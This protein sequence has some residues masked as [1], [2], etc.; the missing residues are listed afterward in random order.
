MAILGRN[1]DGR[2]RIA[3]LMMIMAGACMAVAVAYGSILYRAALDQQAER[4]MEIARSQASL[5]EAIAEHEFEMQG[6]GPG[7]SD[8]RLTLSQLEHARKRFKG[9]GRT[10]EFTLGKKEGDRIVFLLAH[11]HG[12]SATPR[13]VPWVSD[14]AEPM[15]LAL[16][17]FSGTMKGKDYRGAT[18]LAAHEPI[19]HL[20]LGIVAKMDLSE[21]RRPFFHAAL[22]AAGVT[23]FVVLLGVFLF[24]RISDPM[25]RRLEDHAA[26]LEREVEERRQAQEEL[27]ESRRSMETL[28][29]NLPGMAYRG[30][31]RPERPMEFVSEGCRELTGYAPRDLTGDQAMGFGLL[32][33]ESDRDR[34]WRDVRDA[35][36]EDVPFQAEYRIRTK[37]GVE[38]WVWEQGRAV[39]GRPGVPLTLEGFIWD[40][41]ERKKA[42]QKLADSEERFHRAIDFAPFPILIHVEGGDVIHVNE[43]LTRITGYGREDIPTIAIWTEKVHGERAREFQEIIARLYDLEEATRGREVEVNT[44]WGE[45]RTWDFRSAPLGRLPDGRRAVLSIASDVTDKKSAEEQ[46]RQALKMEAVGRLA[47]GVA[48]DFNNMLNVILGYAEM[49]LAA[50]PED[51]ELHQD[52]HEIELA[53]RRSADLTRQLLAFSRKQIVEPKV[54]NLNDVVENQKKMLSRMIGEDIGMMFFPGRDLWS[55]RVDPSQVDQILANLAVNARDAISGVGTVTIETG[56]VVLDETYTRG[57]HEVLPGEY[58]MLAFSDTGAGMSPETL[59]RIF[60]PFFTTKDRDKGTGLGLATVYGIVKQ[61]QGVVNVY[62]EPGMGTTFKMYFPRF[63]GHAA[64]A[65]RPAD[66]RNLEGTETVLVVEDQEQVLNLAKSVLS[67]RGYTVLAARSPEEAL[68]LAKAHPGNIALLLTD[69]VMPSMNGKELSKKV[70]ADRPGLKTLFMSGYTAN[71]IA[72]HGVLDQGIHFLQKPFTIHGLSAKVREVLDSL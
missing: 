66:T 52:I 9:F 34:V 69:V 51:S 46:L 47:G 25:V 16:A 14:L 43:A 28:L 50:V 22:V 61:N 5:I 41:T 19:P 13:P 48:H 72:R 44:A 40:I 26:D 65:A 17:G 45:K 68:D 35:V 21:V 33:P 12:D 31:G 2:G 4:L 39:P 53:A 38:K 57:R 27:A 8:L 64:E 15:R 18:V 55:V 59:E 62:S 49:A 10:G 30:D 70:G 32:I 42:E 11:R 37:E 23:V 36:R 29:G 71:V 60:E 1:A 54:L 24:R 56:N 6:M 7:T 67:K 3:A 58:V 20:S 63:S